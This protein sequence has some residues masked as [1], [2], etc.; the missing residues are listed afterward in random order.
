MAQ[1]QRAPKQWS[2]SKTETITSFESWRQNLVYSLSLD[3]E[4]APFVAEDFTWQKKTVANPYRG[5]VD[6]TDTIAPAI[7]RSRVQKNASLE[8]L[9]GQIANFCPIISRNAI[10][11]GSTSLKD[12]WQ[13]IRQHFGFQS[14]G[15]QFL[16]LSTIRLES[17]ERPED[18]YQRLSAFY[19][20]CLLSSD[21]GILH[22]DE[23]MDED[24][25]PSIENTIVVLWLQL[26]HPGL[27]QLVKQKY[28][29][30]L[31][32]KTIASIK[33]EISQALPSLL[34]ELRSLEEAK[35]FRAV[36]NSQPDR[37]RFPKSSNSKS[38]SKNIQNPQGRRKKMCVLCK[39]AG[40]SNAD[41]H[42]IRDCFFLPDADK[43]AFART[44]AV[45]GEA[46][47]DDDEFE[48]C[49]EDPTTDC[50]LG[51]S[52][53]RVNIVQS[54][55]LDV[56]YEHHAIRLT[57]DCGATTNM[58]R[59]S[60]AH[61][62]GVP[63]KKA[64]QCA[65]QADGV[66]PLDIVGECH[67]TVFRS[68]RP[69]VLSAL[70]VDKLDVDI[71]AGTPFMV[72]NDIAVRPARREIV[73]KGDQVV[74]YGEQSVRNAP[75][76]RRTQALLL[77]GPSQRSVILPGEFIELQ[78]PNETQPDA[79]WALEPRY[80]NRLVSGDEWPPSQEIQSVDHVLRV[81]N[82]SPA[83]VTVRKH[84]HLCQVRYVSP[85]GDI[86]NTQSAVE[87][88]KPA[89]VS[90][91]PSSENVLIDPD[92]CLSHEIKVKFK[93]LHLKYDK[94]FDPTLSKYNNA[95]GKIEGNVNMGPVLPPQRKG[96][97]PQYNQDKLRELQNKF[98]E[99]EQSGVFAKP[100]QVNVSVEYLNLSFLVQKPSGGSRLVTAFGEIGQYSKPQPSLMPNMENVL[101]D[102]AGWKYL[103]KSDLQQSFYQ[104]PLA[105]SAMKYCGVCTP[106]KGV[107]VYTRCAM[108]MP[109]SET[110]LEE[111]MC[112]VLGDLVQ[113]GVVTK[114]ADDL[115]CG[116]NTPEEALHSW[117]KVL[118]ALSRNNLSL[119]VRK[120]V[121]FPK[122]TMILGWIWTQ[123]TLKASAHKISALA[124]V[125]PPKTVRA[126]RSFVGA[127]KVLSR[128]LK[129]YAALV[130]PLEQIT[131]GK[132]S[133]DVIVWSESM[134]H[135]FRAAQLALNDNQTVTLPHPNDPLW[136]V[137][138]AAV[139]E[140]GIGATL[141]VLRNDELRL[142]GFF[143]AKLRKHQ[144]TWLP[145]EVEGLC[146]GVAVSHF[147]PY[148]I[149]SSHVTNLLTDSRPCVQA[150]GK[151]RRGEFSTSSR[152]TSFLSIVSRYQIHV[153]HIS[154]A[155][156]LPSDYASRHPVTCPTANCQ[157]CLF[158]SE[159][160]DSVIRSL[161]IQEVSEGH[162]SMP[163]TT[164]AAWRATQQECPDLR[165]AH[166]H[167]KQGTRPGKKATNIPD[168]K[169][170]LQ[171]VVISNDG[172]MV[173]RGSAPFRRPNDLIVVPRSV[174]PG[175]LTAL[176][177]RFAHPSAYQLKRITS[178]FF[179]ALNLDKAIE[180]VSGTCHQ[181]LAMKSVPKQ[182]MPQR[183][184]D[185]VAHIGSSFALDVMRRCQQ[186]I[187]VL[188]ESVTSYTITML[189]ESE[190]HDDF[191]D[192]ILMMCSEVRL[193]NGLVS[194]RVDSA[195]GLL[196]LQKDP[197]LSK[198]GITLDIG[199]VKNKNKNPVA[200]RAVQELGNELVRVH[201]DGGPITNVMLAMA[202]ANM[203]T[204]IRCDGL[205][206]REIWTQ[207]DQITGEQLPIDDQMIILSQ[208]EARS[209]NHP[210]SE[211]SKA[212]GRSATRQPDIDIGQL[213]YLR[214]DRDKTR[215]RD[216]YIVV[217]T[218]GIMCQVRKFTKSQFRTKTYNVKK[219]ECY[220][221]S[222]TILNTD[223]YRGWETYDGNTDVKEHYVH[224]PMHPETRANDEHHE[225]RANDE[226]HE[227][228][229]ND[230]HHEM[231]AIDE[232]HE[233]RAI[234][235]HHE[236]RA[237]E[238]LVYADP[239]ETLVRSPGIDESIHPPGT[240]IQPPDEPTHPPTTTVTR[241]QRTRT[242]PK[243]LK[244]YIMD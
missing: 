163:F 202:T 143:S 36:T 211:R 88:V 243:R 170:Y 22:H 180:D 139:K 126:L 44:R 58:I 217:A 65:H 157:I 89:K 40:R 52:T 188:R 29:S 92:N 191:R 55:Y 146:I 69:M 80:D 181:C 73:I 25:T 107:R 161:S 49:P 204:R 133:H 85:I 233:T 46:S 117:E 203:N 142:A 102:I 153:S 19:D 11:K 223:P 81:M 63:M 123:G 6:D 149:Q 110:A 62:M 37:L 90:D 134:L 179:F 27:P 70:V 130:N 174:L 113:E 45:L 145:C 10:V 87:S 118:K 225:T 198:N 148:I 100:E 210:A 103:I 101:R 209:A 184:S 128:V 193:L 79:L 1:S 150:Y 238:T 20:D 162:V 186:F 159:L 197:L 231:R 205:S 240:L 190:K 77:R 8:L 42:W 236:T 178:R 115:Y 50:T 43:R 119:S 221:I 224:Y 3:R 112:R 54:P 216:K 17:N 95:S 57:L 215:T 28:G 34:D 84:E 15:A 189:I 97:M 121:V 228:R 207:R 132:Q 98:D 226:H 93:Q 91:T 241:P 78:L 39:A 169:R 141:Y 124:R 38:Y 212:P 156:N 60:A 140:A 131:G 104:I 30:E 96:R 154:G 114:I 137:T 109:G 195:P 242:L 175:L 237:I 24:I 177:I 147:A 67:V 23:P 18:L 158:I 220:C 116:G 14:S 235:E 151:L 41:T 129:G 12:I 138:D 120:T 182:L 82:S 105:H 2:L 208:H 111:L 239:P 7:R 199:N 9:V 59:A 232:H 176:H 152:I 200:E 72:Y 219:S 33:P 61:R 47:G 51:N 155:A 187:I 230:E 21:N 122:T 244:D 26:I 16:D 99:L 74:V 86:T 196:S 183:S 68:G 194:I 5:L 94:V 56:H 31:R 167:L 106:F 136:I 144:I 168:V 213:V 185:P 83:P 75:S 127:Y 172:L 166:A 227:T 66:T 234:D 206:S 173:V 71:L 214:E 4:F 165:R 229:A 76:V 135:H 160:E 218:T 171:S 222:P 108:G 13:K 53:H 48:V 201:P 164:R 32:N 192:A 64:S 125:E 35:S